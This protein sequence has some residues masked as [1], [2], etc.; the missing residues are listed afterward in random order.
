MYN[1]RMRFY[2]DLD[3]ERERVQKCISRFGWT[4]DHNLDWF[5]DSV[6]G[7]KAKPVFVEFDDGSGL[8]AHR[9]PD[10]WRIWSDPLSLETDM[11]K[12]VEEF[13]GGVLKDK[14]IKK[15]WC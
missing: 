1:R 13:S 11:T 8:L 14:K 15:V 2:E 12:R 10:K 5:V 7:E 3:T 4:S 9:Y 6:V